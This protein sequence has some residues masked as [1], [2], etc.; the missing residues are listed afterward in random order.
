MQVFIATTTISNHHWID[1]VL[2]TKKN[3]KFFRVS[4]QFFLPQIQSISSN[5]HHPDLDLIHFCIK[6][7][8]NFFLISHDDDEWC[9]CVCLQIEL[10]KWIEFLFEEFYPDEM[11]YVISYSI[12]ITHRDVVVSMMSMKLTVS[13]ANQNKTIVQPTET[14]FLL[15]KICNDYDDDDDEKNQFPFGWCM[16]V[17][18]CPKPTKNNDNDNDD[19]EK[20]IIFHTPYLS[21]IL[22][23]KW[24][25][26]HRFHH[27]HSSSSS[28]C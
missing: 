17:K 2:I 14:K 3:Q 5:H 15:K 26:F 9:V 27:L 25:A 8:Y 18:P 16:C 1:L 4:F 20:Q 23:K 10:E 7:N 21:N 12:H 22:E 24:F 28:F 13:Q 6:Q 11:Y 19:N